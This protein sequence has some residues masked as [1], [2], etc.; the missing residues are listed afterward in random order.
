VEIL[1]PDAVLCP[2]E[3]CSVVHDGRPLYFDSHHL[4]LHGATL[5]EPMFGTVFAR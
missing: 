4:S 5:L 2:G 3:R 1:Q